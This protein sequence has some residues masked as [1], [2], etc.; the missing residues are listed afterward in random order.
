MESFYTLKKGERAN[1][2]SLNIICEEKKPL[3]NPDT[4]VWGFVADWDNG[5]SVPLFCFKYQ[6]IPHLLAIMS[7]CLYK[8][9]PSEELVALS[10]MAGRFGY[11]IKSSEDYILSDTAFRINL[12]FSQEQPVLE[13]YTPCILQYKGNYVVGQPSLMIKRDGMIYLLQVLANLKERVDRLGSI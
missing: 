12:S 2:V 10:L 4:E 3:K 8:Q 13:L 1:L 11:Y 7:N 5:V 6:D 9:Q